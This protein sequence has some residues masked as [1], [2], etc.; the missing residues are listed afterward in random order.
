MGNGEWVVALYPSPFTHRP[1]CLVL[2]SAMI[3]RSDEISGLGLGRV[4]CKDARRFGHMP[5]TRSEAMWF[6]GLLIG[7]LLSS[8]SGFGEGTLWGGLLGALAGAVFS[9]FR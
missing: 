9:L 8:V 2:S 1:I 4:V 5:R 3:P 7:L 6:I